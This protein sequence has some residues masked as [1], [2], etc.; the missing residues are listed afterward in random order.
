M[1]N[2]QLYIDY[3][4]FQL[5]SS[6]STRVKSGSGS[7]FQSYDS[8]E[9]SRLS[10]C[11]PLTVISEPQTPNSTLTPLSFAFDAALLAVDGAHRTRFEGRA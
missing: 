2:H 5:K 6:S 4:E 10:C 9:P 3:G 11:Q 7:L 1:A 8:Y